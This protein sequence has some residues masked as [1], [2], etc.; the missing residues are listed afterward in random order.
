[1]IVR[2]ARPQ[3]IA[4]AAERIGIPKFRDD[5]KG[6]ASLR[7]DGAP[8]AVVVFDT[9]SACDCNMHIASDGSKRWMTRELLM[10]AFWYPFVTAGLR[11]V[12]GVVPAKNQEAIDFDTKMG[13]QV[14][15]R[16]RDALPDDDVVILGMRRADCPFIPPDRRQ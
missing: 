14:E 8:A 10:E 15:G 1:M 5:A 13:F 16:C 12:T 2:T 7:D 3:D 4:W 9:F 6:I 11:R